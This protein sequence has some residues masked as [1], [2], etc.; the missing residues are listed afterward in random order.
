MDRLVRVRVVKG[1]G[2]REAV[3][4]LPEHNKECDDEDPPW[5]APL[6]EDRV[7]QD[8]D[9]ESEKADPLVLGQQACVAPQDGVEDIGHLHDETKHVQDGECQTI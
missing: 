6:V 9:E 7:E 3:L 1:I 4:H 2:V 8:D 5:L